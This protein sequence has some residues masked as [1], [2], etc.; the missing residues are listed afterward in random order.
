MI[1]SA[2]VKAVPVVGTVAAVIYTKERKGWTWAIP[3][4]IAAHFASSWLVGQLLGALDAVQVMPLKPAEV[5]GGEVKI[6]ASE[7]STSSSSMADVG[8]LAKTTDVI[9]K[10]DNVIRLPTTMGKP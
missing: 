1:R 3:V 10:N 2:L 6:P 7:A 4:G 8:A 5:A 9:D